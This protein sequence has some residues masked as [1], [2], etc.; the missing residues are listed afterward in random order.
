MTL[1]DEPHGFFFRTG[2]GEVRNC[3]MSGQESDLMH[4]TPLCS[5]YVPK[6]VVSEQH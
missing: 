1:P 3:I 5:P 2:S 4:N 6:H